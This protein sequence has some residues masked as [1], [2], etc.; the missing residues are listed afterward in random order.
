MIG[1][2]MKVIGWIVKLMYVFLRFLIG[3]VFWKVRV[4]WKKSKARDKM[5][6]WWDKNIGI[7]ISTWEGTR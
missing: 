5:V 3:L 2:I 7:E 6:L 4:R 1:K